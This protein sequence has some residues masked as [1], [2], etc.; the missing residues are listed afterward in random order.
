MICLT[1]LFKLKIQAF[2]ELLSKTK[3]PMYLSH[4]TNAIIYISY[5]MP[6]ARQRL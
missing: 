2:P 5:D 6:D 4:I 1:E 3:F